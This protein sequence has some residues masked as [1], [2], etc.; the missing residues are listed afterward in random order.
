MSGILRVSK[1]PERYT[2]TDNDII[3][4]SAMTFEARAVLIYL[5]SKPNDWQMRIEDLVKQSPAGIKV[6]RRIVKELE[7]HRYLFRFKYQGQGGRWEWE[8]VVFDRQYSQAD[9]DKILAPYSQKGKMVTPYDP[10]GKTV[11]VRPSGVDIVT[12][13]N[14]VLTTT[15]TGELADVSGLDA[16]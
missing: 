15:T 1:R 13:E 11:T 2:I 5:L 9:I 7:R 6:V 10:N 12:T 14:K 16:R 4:N 3:E 8:S